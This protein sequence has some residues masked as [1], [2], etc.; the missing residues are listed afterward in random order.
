MIVIPRSREKRS[1]RGFHAN[2]AS[3][4]VGVVKIQLAMIGF[5]YEDLSLLIAKGAS[6]TVGVVKI[7][8]AMGGS[9]CWV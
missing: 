9:F 3:L 5:P 1:I 8:F 6:L 7:Q 2:G 4:M